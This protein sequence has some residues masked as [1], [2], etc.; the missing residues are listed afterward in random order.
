MRPPA[1]FALRVAVDRATRDRMTL[2]NALRGPV[3]AR[4]GEAGPRPYQTRDWAAHSGPE[5]RSE[6]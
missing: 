6:R 3:A 5:R 2:G 1:I 4:P